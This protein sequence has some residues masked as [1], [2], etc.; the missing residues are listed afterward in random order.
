MLLP[1]VALPQTQQTYA[2]ALI[3][4]LSQAREYMAPI[5]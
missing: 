3:S 5:M 2:Q 1:V 4:R